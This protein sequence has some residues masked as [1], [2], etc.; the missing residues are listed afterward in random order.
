[1]CGFWNTFLSTEKHVFLSFV[2]ALNGK[3]SSL[4]R[5]SQWMEGT[6]VPVREAFAPPWRGKVVWD[7]ASIWIN[8]LM[9]VASR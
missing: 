1:M 6:Y 3:Y 7:G 4:T 8:N 2:Y 9:R 5:M